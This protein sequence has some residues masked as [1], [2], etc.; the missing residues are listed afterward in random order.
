MQRY[1]NWYHRNSVWA[2]PHLLGHDKDNFCHCPLLNDGLLAYIPILVET[3]LPHSLPVWVPKVMVSFNFLCIIQ[4]FVLSTPMSLPWWLV[5]KKLH[6]RA[7]SDILGY[8]YD[9]WCP[10]LPRDLSLLN[11][12][13]SEG[14]TKNKNSVAHVQTLTFWGN[15]TA[16]MG[17][18]HICHIPE[19]WP[20][21]D[22]TY[23][24][25]KWECLE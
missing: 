1:R 7:K 16:T 14:G 8:W 13:V 19:A 11:L 22:P 2:N 23:L 5:P 17:D 6:V 24:V 25:W 18:V 20:R 9:S 21:S 10:L 4:F 12:G 15:V 3:V